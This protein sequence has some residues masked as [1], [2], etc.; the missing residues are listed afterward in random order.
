MVLISKDGPLANHASHIY[1]LVYTPLLDLGGSCDL[2][3]T[4]KI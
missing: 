3:L 1:S 4:N 2:L